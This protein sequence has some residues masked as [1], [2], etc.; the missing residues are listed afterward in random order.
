MI[1]NNLVKTFRKMY[2]PICH[3]S[4]ISYQPYQVMI[5]DVKNNI[6]VDT[7]ASV[8]V[9]CNKSY[10]TKLNMNQNSEIS[11]LEMADGTKSSNIIVGIGLVKLPILDIDGQKSHILLNDALFVPSFSK[12]ILSVSQAI[13]KGYSFNFNNI[14]NEVM[15]SPD[16]NIFKIIAKHNLYYL[17]H[18]FVV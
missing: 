5:S 3:V 16:G 6:L 13:K 14:G 17:N 7:G 11:F 8:H 1:E 15:V 10:F 12:N 2:S 18:T 9:I 4:K